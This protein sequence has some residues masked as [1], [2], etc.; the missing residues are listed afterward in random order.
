[1]SPEAGRAG[2]R[3]GCLVTVP[4]FVMLFLLER[5]TGEY[6]ITII[7]L[8]MGLTFMAAIAA[9]AIYTQR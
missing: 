4:S 5:G 6:Y 9:V 7:T 3:I 1:M 8:V 2:F